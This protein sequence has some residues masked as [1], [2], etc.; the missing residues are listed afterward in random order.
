MNIL[1]RIVYAIP[2]FDQRI[3]FVKSLPAHARLLDVGCGNGDALCRMTGCRPDISVSA[4]D[5][6]EFGKC[7]PA[8]VKFFKLDVE[9]GAL[10]F[11]NDSFDGVSI[12][13]VVEHLNSL[14]GILSEIVRV[15]KPGGVCYLETPDART[16][17][18]PSL[19]TIASKGDGGPLNF[20]DDKTHQRVWP[21]DDMAAALAK[22]NVK[23]ARFGIYR[24]FLYAL[25]SPLL[26]LA[27]AATGKRR[28]FVVGIHHLIGWSRYA[29]FS[30][31]DADA[32]H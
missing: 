4:I 22:L 18:V 19:K 17:K 8:R 27:G 12:I 7:L 9:S 24:N 10:P 5:Q 14:E 26:I 21:K 23:S 29:V 6:E 3:S 2:A 20:Y 15:L 16:L 13:H 1:H 28:P 32:G 25:L 30:K 31:G 11:G